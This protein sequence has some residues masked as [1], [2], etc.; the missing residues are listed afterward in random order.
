[1]L[2]RVRAPRSGKPSEEHSVVS[3]VSDR[4][5]SASSARRSRTARCRHAGS[6]TKRARG[7][8]RQATFP[9]GAM[10]TADPDPSRSNAQAAGQL[11]GGN[12][13]AFVFVLDRHQQPLMPCHPA[14]ARELLG[15]GRAAVVRRHPFTVRLTDRIGGDVQPVV[16]GIDPGSK[17]TGLALARQQGG[18]RHAL[19]L[20]ELHHRGNQIHKKLEQRRQY[21][22]RRRSTNLRYR[23]PRFQNRR[24]PEGWLAPSLRHRV[25]ATVN[26]AK[27]FQ[28]WVPLC[29]IAVELVKFDPQ[30]LANPEISGTEYQEG[31]LFGYEVREYLLEKWGRQCAYCENRDVPLQIEHMVP[32]SRGGSDRVSNLTLACERCNQDK[33]NQTAA[34]FG[35]A[36][37]EA[38][39]QESLKDAAAINATRRIVY[40]RL[41]S[42]GFPV[43]SGTGARTKWNRSRLRLPKTHALDA[44]CVG[45]VEGV[46]HWTIVPLRLL[47]TG[48]GRYQRTRVSANGVPRGYLMRQK[49]VWGFRTGDLVR[50]VVAAGRKRGVYTGRLAV[51]ASGSF[52]IQTRTEIVQGISY[53]HCRLV[54]RADGHN[55]QRLATKEGRASS[56]V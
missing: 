26:W 28:R 23:A 35:Y 12:S 44:L 18:I 42:L 40:Q 36:H 48:R 38:H 7:Q 9:R 39:A 29:H 16:L 50:A 17:Y 21:R 6:G 31:T 20:G 51:R 32:T 52:N 1:M 30:A 22:R 33:G 55:Y 24:R 53:R 34:E 5:E 10:G 3:S 56:V 37:I 43:T 11:G 4:P 46:I 47:T 13:S 14:R 19:W 27:R 41:Q 8:Y 15:K 45:S 49:T 2:T 54:M 25:E